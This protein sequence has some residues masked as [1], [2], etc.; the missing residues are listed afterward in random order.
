MESGCRSV[1]GSR[2]VVYPQC[3]V[4]NDN[5]ST[6]VNRNTPTLSQ[7]NLENRSSSLRYGCPCTLSQCFSFSKHCTFQ[8]WPLEW[9]KLKML[10]LCFSVDEENNDG[11]RLSPPT[12]FCF[13]LETILVFASFHYMLFHQDNPLIL[14][15]GKSWVL[16]QTAAWLGLSWW[17]NFL[18]GPTLWP[19]YTVLL[20]FLFCFCKWV[21]I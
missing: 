9:K 7:L 12:F 15:P 1:L 2:T 5:P 3:C 16:C 19:L 11:R 8:R 4:D 10:I 17:S 21:Y 6:A 18:C 20:L 14:D 13:L